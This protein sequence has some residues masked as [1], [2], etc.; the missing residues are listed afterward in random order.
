MTPPPGFSA[1]T[2]KPSS[3]ELPPISVSTFIATAPENT[4]LNNCASILTNPDS[5]ISLAFVE[6]NYEILESLLRERRKKIRNE[7]RHTK[8]KY[9]SEDHD[10][11][12]EMEP[13]PVRNKETIPV[14]RTRV[15]INFE[16]GRPSG[17][18]ADNNKIQRKNI[19]PLL[20]A[21]LERSENGQ[22]LQLSL[23]SIHRGPQPSINTGGNL[24]L[25]GMHLS[26][27]AQPFIPSNL[28]PTNRLMPT[29]VNLYSQP[30]MGV[31][32][33]QSLNYPPHAQN[34]NPSF[35]GTFVEY[36]QGGQQK[37]ITKT[38]LTVHNIK[39][40]EGQSTRAFVTRSLVEFL[41]TYLPTT[42][43]GLMEKTY[44]SIEARDVATNGAPNDRREGFNKSKKNPSW[45]NNKGQKNKDRFSSYC[46]SNHGLLSNLSKSPKEILAT[47]KVARTFE[48]PPCM[49]ENRRSRDMTKYF[50]FYEDH[51]HD[52]NDCRELR[53]QIKEAV[54]GAAF[55]SRQGNKKGKGKK[56]R[57]PNKRKSL[58]E[59]TPGFEEITFPPVARVNTSSDPVII[60]AKISGRQV[61]RVHMDIGSSCEVIYEHCFLKLKP[62]IKSLRVDSK[63][64]LIGFSRE[65]S[66]P[67]GEVPLEITKG[68]SP[69]SRTKTL[70]FVI[71]R[72][73]SSHNLLLRR[74]AMQK[75]GIV[76]STIHRAIKFYTPREIGIVLSTYEFGKMREGTKKPREV[77]SEDIKGIL[78][79]TDAKER[80]II[81][82]KYPEL[83]L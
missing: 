28:Q 62:S 67:I 12:R 60:K 75:I 4:P 2:P 17:L 72:P 13:R 18:G 36:S 1:L 78:S 37:K 11:E 47:E 6:A 5:M 10:K 39:K 9:F 53:H 71:I 14:L 42:Y 27:N 45:D 56:P 46:G 8:L 49:L 70:N 52:T 82:R 58:E 34:G 55:P 31:T 20:A 65:H 35:G 40:R 24:P 64:S 59:L 51:S 38:H 7:E 50:H 43:K 73:N 44:T 3:N 48:Q 80:I 69:F 15:E 30:H 81:N 25:N 29:N 68:D 32:L 63:V 57:T 41:S 22:P 79:C 66:S 26:H 33:R 61:N 16:G 83:T 54:I 23:T 76:V 77:S 19:P 21:H 74:T